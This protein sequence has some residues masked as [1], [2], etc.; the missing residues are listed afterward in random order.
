M[1]ASTPAGKMLIL[2][3][4]LAAF[5][6]V[7]TLALFAK[8]RKAYLL[9]QNNPKNL[10][11]EN[12]R[13]LF[14]PTDEDIRAFELA[15]NEKLLAKEREEIKR[16]AEEKIEKVYEMEK[17]WRRSPDRKATAKLLFSVSE[18]SNAKIYGEIAESVIKVW[19]EDK[20]GNLSAR[21]LADLLDSHF[22]ILPQQER[23]SGAIFW[24]REE[25]EK[26][27]SKSEAQR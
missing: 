7:I 12:F 22:R 19:R 13:P 9:E 3:I 10:P 8:R 6:A 11:A 26:L 5:S 23:T 16:L 24:L 25:I 27:R 15:E 17:N 2:F 4:I 14:A 20:I 21:D 1:V 18:L